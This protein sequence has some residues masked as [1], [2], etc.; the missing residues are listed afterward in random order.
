ME[1]LEALAHH[2]MSASFTSFLTNYRKPVMAQLNEVDLPAVCFSMKSLSALSC[3]RKIICFIFL[4]IQLDANGRTFVEARRMLSFFK[5][6]F[7][8]FNVLVL[9][10]LLVS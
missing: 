2:P 8:V 9:Y 1:T 7:D 5:F 4:Q 10:L 3:I 6:Y